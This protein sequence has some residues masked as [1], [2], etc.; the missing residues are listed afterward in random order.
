[1]KWTRRKTIIA[2][3]LNIPA[4]ED[5][6]EENYHYPVVAQTQAPKNPKI[7][8]IEKTL[9]DA[10]NVVENGGEVKPLAKKAA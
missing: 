9:A 5:I 8:A 2:G 1:M 7:E 6:Q 3:Y 10:L 4:A